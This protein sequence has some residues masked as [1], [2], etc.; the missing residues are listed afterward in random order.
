MR[1]K[2]IASVL[3]MSLTAAVML[4]L[5]ACGGSTGADSAGENVTEQTASDKQ[6]ANQNDKQNDQS[7]AEQKA[8]TEEAEASASKESNEGQ[9]Q[10]AFNLYS[11]LAGLE[12]ELSSVPQYDSNYRTWIGYLILRRIF[13][14][15][16]CPQKMAAFR[17]EMCLRR[18]SFT[19]RTE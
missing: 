12:F 16:L 19:S 2:T 4:N 6:N 10:E 7:N 14:F 15:T 13:P 18:M 11:E 3:C 17:G 9:D 5:S 1:K 8:K